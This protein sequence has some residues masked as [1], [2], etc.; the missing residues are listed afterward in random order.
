MKLWE[1]V[2]DRAVEVQ[3][4][5]PHLA[6][7]VM[8]V[9]SVHNGSDHGCDGCGRTREGTPMV[10]IL[11]DCPTLRALAWKWADHPDWRKHWAVPTARWLVT[12]PATMNC[13]CHDRDGHPH[14]VGTGRHC[15]GPARRLAKR[16]DRRNAR[17]DQTVGATS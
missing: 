15:Q 6:D 10:S 13:F 8:A 3:P 7:A 4:T 14:R 17:L 5:D 11:D 9:L 2:R 1:F 16:L 12:W